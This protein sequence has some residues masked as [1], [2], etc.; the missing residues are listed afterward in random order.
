MVSG[1]NFGPINVYP[2][3]AQER[4][5]LL[6]LVV[7]EGGVSGV[8]FR[9]VRMRAVTHLA[10][11]RSGGLLLHDRVVTR[12]RGAKQS[13]GVVFEAIFTFDQPLICV[14]SEVPE[15]GGYF[16]SDSGMA[17][18]T[19]LIGRFASSKDREA[20]LKAELNGLADAR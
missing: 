17:E 10:T 8:D 18:V 16:L 3:V 11:G 9:N 4:A 2:S 1:L 6:T 20:W 5:T 19:Q 7:W 14:P 13:A 15:N 12:G